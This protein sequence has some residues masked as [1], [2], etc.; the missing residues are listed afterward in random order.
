MAGYRLYCFDDAGR[1]ASAEW[2]DARNDDEAIDLV[3]DKKIGLECEIWDHDRRV[4]ALPAS[5][6]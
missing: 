4:A 2:L 6:D 5:A 3:R 1:I